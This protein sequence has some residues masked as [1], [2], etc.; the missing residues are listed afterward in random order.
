M[1][2]EKTEPLWQAKP[3]PLFYAMFRFDRVW[4]VS[5]AFLAVLFVI[6]HPERA[7]SD[8]GTVASLVITVIVAGSLLQILFAIWQSTSVLYEFDGEALIERIGKKTRKT[9]FLHYTLAKSRH[10]CIFGHCCFHFQKG[11]IFLLLGSQPDP[12]LLYKKQK[13]FHE[14]RK[15]VDSGKGIFGIRKKDADKLREVLQTVDV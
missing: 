7:S 5:L 2:E 12:R 3:T 11:R 15:D 13:F 4:P 8:S 14:F 1:S 6:A 9:E 10:Y